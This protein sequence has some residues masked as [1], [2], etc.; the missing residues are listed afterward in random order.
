MRAACSSLGVGQAGGDGV[1][2]IFGKWWDIRASVDYPDRTS[3]TNGAAYWGY[4]D[5][6]NYEQTFG[7][8][9]KHVGADPAFD[10][11]RVVPTFS[12]TRMKSY[13]VLPCAYLGAPGI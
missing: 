6:F 4:P 7:A 9:Y 11:S 2:N 3:S 13:G 5:Y 1:R 10:A 8:Q 12:V